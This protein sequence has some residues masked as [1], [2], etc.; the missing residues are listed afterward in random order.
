M[1]QKSVQWYFDKR[2]ITPSHLHFKQINPACSDTTKL[3]IIPWAH[4]T[5]LGPRWDSSSGQSYLVAVITE[6]I[7]IPTVWNT[8][9]WLI[10]MIKID[11]ALI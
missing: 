4:Y 10:L 5:E 2:D 9:K 8:C 1:F 7:R 3:I 11:R 6:L